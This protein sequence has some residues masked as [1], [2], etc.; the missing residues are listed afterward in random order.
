MGVGAVFISTLAVK[1][2]QDPQ[3]PQQQL[4]AAT[5]QPI[6][7]FVVLGSIVIRKSFG[8]QIKQLKEIRLQMG[9]RSHFSLRDEI[10]TRTR[11]R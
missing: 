10:C 3:T 11:L 4:L 8:A 9:Y 1:R 2:L 5:L 7:A 6:V